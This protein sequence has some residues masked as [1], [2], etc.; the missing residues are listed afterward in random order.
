MGTL[1][2]EGIELVC[3]QL[4]RAVTYQTKWS[5]SQR[6]TRAIAQ[7]AWIEGRKK[8]NMARSGFCSLEGWRVADWGWLDDGSV[9]QGA[10]VS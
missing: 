3:R 1:V 9:S 5:K 7:P 4:A 2:Y 10:P 8:N 6:F